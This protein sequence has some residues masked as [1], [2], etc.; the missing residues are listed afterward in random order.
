MHHA[1]SAAIKQPLAGRQCGQASLLCP[2][3][4]RVVEH[5]P[6]AM[7]Q[8]QGSYG[9]GIGEELVVWVRYRGGC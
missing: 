5:V 8:P 1:I 4:I 9:Q 2:P 3:H 6:F 7:P